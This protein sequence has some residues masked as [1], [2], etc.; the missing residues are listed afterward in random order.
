[1]TLLAGYQEQFLP[2]AL[3]ILLTLGFFIYE[4]L[5]PGRALPAV[6]GWYARAA[7]MNLLQLALI[8]LGGLTWNRYFRDH[9]LLSL[10]AW[11]NP[12]LEGAF[13]WFVGTFV[14]YWWHRLRHGK[15]TQRSLRRTV[16][17]GE[18]KSHE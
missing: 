6:P 17:R 12:V 13:Y 3:I 14:F 16:H 18:D 4:R 1:M 7:A 5:R 2:A 9:A 8:G 10:G 15:R 11:S